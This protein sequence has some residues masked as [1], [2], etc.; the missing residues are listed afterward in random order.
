MGQAG[1]AWCRPSAAPRHGGRFLRTPMG[2][3]G[4]PPLGGF[5]RRER[6]L[7]LQAWY[8]AA[9]RRHAPPPE[10]RWRPG[11]PPAGMVPPGMVPPEW[12]HLLAARCTAGEFAG[13]RQ[14]RRAEWCRRNDACDCRHG[15]RCLLWQARY[16]GG[17]VLQGR[18]E[19]LLLQ[20]R[21]GAACRRHGVWCRLLPARF[22]WGETAAAGRSSGGY[23]A[24]DRRHGMMLHVG[25]TVPS[26][27]FRR[28]DE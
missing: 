21:C 22:T 4:F 26:L 7:R 11:F 3:L 2:V 20:A 1:P 13:G 8:G 15:E 24:A 9:C 10:F 6:C 5:R 28:R 17:T 14:S 27:G 12:C 25:S 23:G 16:I 19:C 18:H